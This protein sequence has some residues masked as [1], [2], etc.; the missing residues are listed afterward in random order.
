MT[1][2][3]AG[4][5]A[6]SNTDAVGMAFVAQAV[7]MPSAAMLRGLHE[8]PE[9]AEL[10]KS[11]GE[12]GRV[13]ADALSGGNAAAIDTLLDALAG[14][15]VASQALFAVRSWDP[16]AVEFAAVAGLAIA[17]E[18]LVLHQDSVPAA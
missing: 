13:L 2:L 7:A 17:T 9:V 3:L 6:P 8:G 1:Q 4:T 12:V 5:E 11:N 14:P 10:A 18:S 15:D 16:G